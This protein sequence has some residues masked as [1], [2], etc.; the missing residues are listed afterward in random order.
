MKIE[1]GYPVSRRHQGGDHT[2]LTR[3]SGFLLDKI[4]LLPRAYKFVFPNMVCLRCLLPFDSGAS[5]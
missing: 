2:P 4:L 5:H 3:L 1:L